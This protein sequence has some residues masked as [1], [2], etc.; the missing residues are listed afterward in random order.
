LQRVFTLVI[1]INLGLAQL[2]LKMH[3]FSACVNG[4]SQLSL[5]PRNSAKIVVLV[6]FDV[7]IDH[8]ILSFSAQL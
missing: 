3:A 2:A 7:K 4:V 6:N 1:E 8:L 5:C